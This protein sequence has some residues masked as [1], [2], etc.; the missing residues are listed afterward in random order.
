MTRKEYQKQ[1]QKEYAASG[2]KKEAQKRYYEKHK[3]EINRKLKGKRFWKKFITSLSEED[4]YNFPNRDDFMDSIFTKER[5][6]F[7]SEPK[8]VKVY[9]KVVIAKDEDA[10]NSIIRQVEK[11]VKT[12]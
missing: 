2:K 7:K 12:K 3:Y 10:N 5:N 9:G 11:V 4:K 6:G 1:Y 8:V